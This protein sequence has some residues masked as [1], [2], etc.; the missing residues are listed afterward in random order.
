MPELRE[1]VLTR[2]GSGRELIRHLPERDVGVA[3]KI[4]KWTVGPSN[5]EPVDSQKGPAPADFS[6]PIRNSHRYDLHSRFV[7]L[8]DESATDHDRVPIKL[9]QF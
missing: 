6:S 5:L 9:L 1:N 8:I 4:Y 7:G 3:N 2:I